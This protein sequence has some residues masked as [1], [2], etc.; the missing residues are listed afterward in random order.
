MLTIVFKIADI[1]EEPVK[2]TQKTEVELAM[3]LIILTKNTTIKTIDCL[4]KVEIFQQ[5]K[6]QG[7]IQMTIVQAE[8]RLSPTNVLKVIINVF[9]IVAEK[10]KSNDGVYCH[11]NE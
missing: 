7:F 4:K 8:N 9:L 5:T 10:S 1:K 11:A 2:T 6:I 3:C